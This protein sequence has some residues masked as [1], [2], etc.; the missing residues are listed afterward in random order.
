MTFCSCCLITLFN[1]FNGDWY[2]GKGRPPTDEAFMRADSRFDV[3]GD[4]GAVVGTIGEVAVRGKVAAA[5]SF[6]T[7]LLAASF[8]RFLGGI[9]EQGSSVGGGLQKEKWHQHPSTASACVQVLRRR[10]HETRVQ[11]ET[12]RSFDKKSSRAHY[13]AFLKSWQSHW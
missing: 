8:S 9:V 4:R 13:A 1:F 11:T 6:I 12:R 2:P 5:A 7:C 3:V 10:A